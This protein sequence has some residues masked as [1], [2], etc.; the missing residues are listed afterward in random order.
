MIGGMATLR[1]AIEGI[2][3]IV[4]AYYVGESL[5]SHGMP[6]EH[7]KFWSCLFIIAVGGCIIMIHR[8][9]RKPPA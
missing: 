6:E 1:H 4:S 5:Q 2:L 8:R 3:V 7:A 9:R